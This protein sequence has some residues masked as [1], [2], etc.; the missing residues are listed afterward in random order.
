MGSSTMEKAAAE[1]AAG[2]HAFVAP[3]CLQLACRPSKATKACEA[4]ATPRY[5]KPE[6][7]N[8]W[9]SHRVVLM[10]SR[11]WKVTCQAHSRLEGRESMT[12][13]C[14]SEIR[15]YVTPLLLLSPPPLPG[16]WV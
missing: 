15:I 12:P 4:S 2:C 14:F 3:K 6:R 5:P 16:F 8:G 13:G 11:P 9:R 10:L 7:T 1:K